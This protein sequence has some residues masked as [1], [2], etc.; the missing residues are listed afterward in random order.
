MFSHVYGMSSSLVP[1]LWEETSILVSQIPEGKVSTYGSIAEA[2]GDR[3]AARFVALAIGM[4]PGD[5]S[6]RVVR[7]DGSFGGVTSSESQ[8]AEKSKRLMAE[9]VR[10]VRARVVDIEGSL[11][12]GFRTTKPLEALRNDQRR[13]RRNLEIPAVDIEAERV[14]G[15]DVAYEGNRAWAALATFDISS[16]ALLRTDCLESVV[17]FP[18]IPTYLAY[19]ELPIVG[20]LVPR[21]DERTVLMYDGN[22]ILHPEGFGIASHAGVLFGLPTIGVAKRLLCGAPRSR[23]ETPVSEIEV[24]GEV[25][26]YA[27]SRD[28]RS[29]IY[30]SPGHGMGHQQCLSI[31]RSFLKHRIPEPIR[32][33]HSLA[34]Q[35]SR[36]ASNK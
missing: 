1:D 30:V 20:P 23:E 25:V 18:Y 3:R 4:R 6:F 19:R 36:S 11:F 15:V 14:A 17:R 9:G 24:D 10:V 7:S 2:L 33:A 29:P 34:R 27:L 32:I 8:V 5:A 26:G 28:R 21:G 22:G 35:A 13:M 31:V 16:G 12:D